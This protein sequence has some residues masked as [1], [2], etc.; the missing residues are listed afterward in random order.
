KAF[1]LTVANAIW[2]QEGYVFRDSFMR[3]TVTNY[4]SAVR[5]VDFV[6]APEQARTQINEWAEQQTEGRIKDLVPAGAVNQDTR[7]VLANAIYYKASWLF[8]FLP[9]NTRPANFVTSEGEVVSV[10]TMHQ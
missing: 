5:Q 7:L 6:H 9:E 1:A 4:D 10:A 3:H 2:G 8:E